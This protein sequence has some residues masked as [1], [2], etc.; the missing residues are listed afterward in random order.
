MGVC[1]VDL[2]CAAT[3]VALG[4]RHPHVRV[5]DLEAVAEL[6]EAHLLDL[7]PKV[8]LQTFH[9]LRNIPSVSSR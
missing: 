7:H 1:A 3:Y 5:P 4:V 2:V 8:G 9:H 6:G